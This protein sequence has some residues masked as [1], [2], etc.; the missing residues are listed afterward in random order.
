MLAGFYVDCERM[1]IMKDIRTKP[2]SK[3][4]KTLDASAR[5]PR[6][7]KA[8]L[9][10]T[11]DRTKEAEAHEEHSPESYATD[12]TWRGASDAANYGVRIIGRTLKKLSKR[13][14]AERSGHS[15]AEQTN[16]SNYSYGKEPYREHTAYQTGK[17]EAERPDASINTRQTEMPNTKSSLNAD[18]IKSHSGH[19][20]QTSIQPVTRDAQFVSQ[21]KYKASVQL[22]EAIRHD[23]KTK[24]GTANK[25]VKSIQKSIKTSERTVK[26]GTQAA[27]ATAKSAKAASKAARISAQAMRHAAR[28][29]VKGIRLLVKASIAAIRAAAL[30]VKSIAA[31]I[32]AGGWV[33]ILIVLVVGALSIILSSAFGIF[34][35]NEPVSASAITISQVV[36]EV[37][38]DFEAYVSSKAAEASKG[39]ENV[40]V[41]YDGDSDGDSDSVNNWVDVL[42]IFAVKTTMDASAPSDVAILTEDKEKAIHDLLFEMNTVSTR[43]ETKTETKIVTDEDGTEHE[44]TIIKTYVY[45]TV[46]SMDAQDVATK[47]QFSDE[48]NK[49]LDELLSP[50]NY[51]LFAEITGVDLYGGIPPEDIRKIIRNLPVGTK[52]AA[53][54]QAALTRLGD[55]YSMAKR[56]QGRCVDCSYF[57]RWAYNAAGVDNYKAATAAEQARYCVNHNVIISKDQLQPGDVVFWRKN[58]CTCAGDH[59]GRYM[60]IH[61]VAIYIGDDKLIEASSS[62]GRVVIRNIWGEGPGKWQ[63]ILYARPHIIN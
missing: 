38:G 16:E 6:T 41:I 13:R 36:G 37:N 9:L 8:M 30:A 43:M 25:S 54:V 31:A 46:S 4:P 33:V 17:P 34:Y 42:G 63:I 29:A 44:E 62:K 40:T 35:S 20:S 59:C 3:G 58:G 47:Y 50:E 61:H 55:P 18:A 23:A 57:V 2:V 53:I 11:K 7:V 60:K 32:A 45:V 51:P 48:Q 39:H 56:G 14:H 21:P 27:K 28:G 19:D 10:K 52:G 26:I 49:M 12:R 22:K 15:E 5:L 24:V 1:P